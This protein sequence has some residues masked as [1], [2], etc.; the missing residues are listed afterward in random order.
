[1]ASNRFGCRLTRA[2]N[3]ETQLL[4]ARLYSV[5]WDRYLVPQNVFLVHKNIRLFIRTISGVVAGDRKM[6]N[7]PPIFRLWEHFLPN[8]QHLGLKI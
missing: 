6:C 3:A 2:S 4:A 1:M 7:F 5:A 8:I